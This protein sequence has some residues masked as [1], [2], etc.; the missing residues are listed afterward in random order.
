MPGLLLCGL[1]ACETG[2][3]F[4]GFDGPPPGDAGDAGGSDAGGPGAADAGNSDAGGTGDAGASDAGTFDA[5][6]A[7]AGDAGNAGAGSADAGNA[8]AG[9]ADA[10]SADAG[11]NDGGVAAAGP[12]I[13]GCPV[14]PPSSEWSRDV[15]ADPVDPGSDHYLALMNASTTFVHPDFGST[16]GYGVPY[17]TVP[18]SQPAASMSFLYAGQ[19]DPGPYP[20][21]QTVIIQA[22][23][24][25]HAVVIDRDRCLL[26]ETYDTHHD[27]KGGFSC[28]SGARFDLR[29][30]A[31][32]PDGWTS[33]T[34]SGLPIFPGLVRYDEAV[35][36]G[37][38]H[39]ALIYT[40]GAT[41]HFYVHPATH[42][43]G[44]STDTA[45]PPMGLRLRLRKSYDISRFTGVSRTVVL[46][47][48]RY[49][50]LLLDNGSNFSIGGSSDSRWPDPDLEQLKSI[51]GTAFEAVQVGTLHAGSL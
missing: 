2:T 12:M 31:L 8:G 27:G 29:T 25:L 48:Q 41:S 44:T 20:F 10:G 47:L 24:D 1:L 37:E 28:G 11:S 21:P 14:F 42:E 6:D 9:N 22:G 7:G 34:A 32:R 4:P 38:I 39:H 33:A 13:D 23:A 26:Y 30:G 15:S 18:G 45:A 3:G 35:Q 16:P 36:A 49:G 43:V 5:G 17:A 19:S 50:M 40:S 46:A 51:P